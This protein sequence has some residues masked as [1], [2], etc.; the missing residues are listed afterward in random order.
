MSDRWQYL[1]VLAACLAITAPLEALGPGVYRQ[2]RR[3]IKA[4]LPVA[5]VFLIWDEIA[6]AAHVWTYDGAYLSGLGIPFR[7]PIE[8]VLFFFVIPVCALLTYNAVSAI[9]AKVR[10]R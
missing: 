9:L 10:R 5:A 3:L 4:V 7:V 8:E 6:V 2:W 1:V